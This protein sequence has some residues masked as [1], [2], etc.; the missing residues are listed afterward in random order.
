MVLFSSFSALFK[1]VTLSSS[2]V[3][4]ARRT[5]QH[6]TP[7]QAK[8]A[9]IPAK[10]VVAPVVEKKSSTKSTR[11]TEKKVEIKHNKKVTNKNSK[12]KTCST[13]ASR[14]AESKMYKKKVVDHNPAAKVVSPGLTIN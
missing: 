2:S 12:V 5:Y 4:V 9:Q 1:G 13:M 6:P 8:P 3:K 11:H 14:L 10:M 7:T